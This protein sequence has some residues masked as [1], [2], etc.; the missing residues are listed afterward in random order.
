MIG[1]AAACK[2]NVDCGVRLVMFLA[3][4]RDTVALLSTWHMLQDEARKHG[5]SRD[6]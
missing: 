6:I 1:H 3:A 2:D 5:T 4:M